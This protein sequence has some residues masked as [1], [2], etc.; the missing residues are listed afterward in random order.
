MQIF[1]MAS[2]TIPHKSNVQPR[3][4][5]LYDLILCS[6]NIWFPEHMCG[7]VFVCVTVVNIC[8]SVS[9][10]QLRQPCVLYNKLW[11]WRGGRI[12]RCFFKSALKAPQSDVWIAENIQ[13]GAEVKVGL[14][15]V[16]RRSFQVWFRGHL[17]KELK[18]TK[19][20]LSCCSSSSNLEPK[21]GFKTY[22][23]FFIYLFLHLYF[24]WVTS[25]QLRL[26]LLSSLCI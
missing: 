20:S 5:V 10:K 3:S 25:S 13:P 11:W 18:K 8:S 17:P 22:I 16:F 7:R 26:T 1:F 14:S 6:S 2:I 4:I 24:R 12:L 23:L 21:T 19:R 9:L 15:N